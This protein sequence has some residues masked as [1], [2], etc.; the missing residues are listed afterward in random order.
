MTIFLMHQIRPTRISY[1]ELHIFAVRAIYYMYVCGMNVCD[2]FICAK[3]RYRHTL[4]S[5]DS[6]KCQFPYKMYANSL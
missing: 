1:I 2:T 4:H 5:P 6:L 3:C